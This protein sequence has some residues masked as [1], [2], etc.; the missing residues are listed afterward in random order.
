MKIETISQCNRECKIN[1]ERLIQ[2]LI[3]TLISSAVPD[4]SNASL[5]T[6]KTPSTSGM[7]KSNR[8]KDA[9]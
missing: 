4:P 8:L 6:S 9:T 1:K 3:H 2:I 5:L 7:S